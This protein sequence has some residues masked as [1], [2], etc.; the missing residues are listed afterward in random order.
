MAASTFA[1]LAASR[2]AADGVDWVGL[3]VSPL[4]GAGRRR[5]EAQGG[6]STRREPSQDAHGGQVNGTT[7]RDARER[8]PTRASMRVWLLSTDAQGRQSAPEPQGVNMALIGV[9]LLLIGAGAAIVTY[10]GAQAAGGT[11]ALT[12][13]GFTRN[14]SPLEL[15]IYAAAAVLLL[16]LGWALLSAAA[17]R[18]ARAVARTRRPLVWPRS[19]R[20]PRLRA[21]TRS[22]ASR[23]PGCVTR[24]CAAASPSWPPPRRPRRPRGRAGPSRGGVARAPG[25]VGRRRRDGARRGQRARG[26]RV[27]VRRRHPRRH[28][29]LHR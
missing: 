16:A 19:R 26:H 11:I 10:I 18:R 4:P 21:S 22:T 14:V 27:V 12:A 7:R 5:H 28:Q 17:R 15:A 24:T 20:R 29:R 9:I 2:S 1:L 25:P 3:G 6:E 23:R 8:R 13:L